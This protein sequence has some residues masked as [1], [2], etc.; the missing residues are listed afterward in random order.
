MDAR[1]TT[2]LPITTAVL[3]TSSQTLWGLQT[4]CEGSPSEPSVL[5][6]EVDASQQY[7]LSHVKML[8]TSWLRPKLYHCSNWQFQAHFDQAGRTSHGEPPSDHPRLT[9][10]WN[11]LN[12]SKFKAR[13]NSR[14]DQATKNCEL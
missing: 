7:T 12:H 11:K 4:Q 13:G 1:R 5:K 8:S 3:D 14:F 10:L 9:R 6:M 2:D